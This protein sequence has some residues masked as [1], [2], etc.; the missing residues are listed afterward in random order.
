MTETEKLARLLCRQS[1]LDP[2][3]LEPGDAYGVDKIIK[4]EPCHYMWRHFVRDAED[5]I[6]FVKLEMDL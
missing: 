4:G 6:E 2:D 5:I 3:G 1:G